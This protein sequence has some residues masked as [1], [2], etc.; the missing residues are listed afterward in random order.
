[1]KYKKAETFK[2]DFKYYYPNFEEWIKQIKWDLHMG[3]THK[4]IRT[5]RRIPLLKRIRQQSGIYLITNTITKKK[6]VG[7][8]SNLLD[9]F[10]NYSSLNYLKT[11]QNSLICKALLKF[12][13]SKFSVTLIEYCDKSKL[14]ERE[15]Y[16]I[17]TLKP[18]YNIRKVVNKILN[19]PQN[20]DP[21]P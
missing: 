20:P 10:I 14:S 8:S 3:W 5:S 12:G 7:K 19:N 2:L 1:M 16:F 18:Q 15:Q 6:Y 13:L 17:D 4:G 21:K 11:K 9:R